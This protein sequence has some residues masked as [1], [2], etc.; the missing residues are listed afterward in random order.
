MDLDSLFI[1]PCSK[2]IKRIKE[3]TSI[4]ILGVGATLIYKEHRPNFAILLLKG[5]AHVFDDSLKIKKIFNK[6]CLIGFVQLLE[7]A[8]LKFHI[9]I[10]K[11]SEVCFLDLQVSKTLIDVDFRGLHRKP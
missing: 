6:S 3:A 8:P 11:G 7:R 4:E 2:D 9:S 10:D 1:Y 5:A